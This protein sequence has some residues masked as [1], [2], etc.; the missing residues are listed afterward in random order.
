MTDKQLIEILK[1][2]HPNQ[3]YVVTWNNLLKLL[4]TPFKVSV[5]GQLEGFVLG[6]IVW[7]DEVKVTKELKTVFIIKGHAYNYYYFDILDVVVE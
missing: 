6:E 2:S 1:Y 3:L 7:V 5:L 4:I